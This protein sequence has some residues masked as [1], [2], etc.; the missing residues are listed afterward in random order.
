MD[1]KKHPK[2]F[3]I[4]LNYNG[5]RT[6]SRCLTSIY[7]SDYPN[8]E[9]IVVD[10]ASR[11]GSIETIR[12]N[13]QTAHIIINQANL[14]FAAGNNVAIRFALEK[15]ADY[16]LLLN[17]DAYLEPKTISALVLQAQ[18][19]KK[20]GMIN[21]LIL[22]SEGELW[23]EGGKIDWL[24]MRTFHSKLESEKSSN[25]LCGCALLISKEV[26]HKIGLFDEKFFLYYEDADL[27][28]RAKKA[29]F[30]LMIDRSI[31]I[32]HDEQSESAGAQKIYWLVLSGIIFFKKHTPSILKPWMYF[33]L[34]LRRLKNARDLAGGKNE[35]A[36]AVRRAYNDASKL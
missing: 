20:V 14:G 36:S 8:F 35:V 5:K 10:N 12:Q 16:V 9:T 31:K 34:M 21:P 30:S 22:N 18:K 4:V 33:Y 24:K 13:F 6:I 28:L 32:I 2:V 3:V 7:H 15:F 17:N 19:D 23:F 29:G 27:S 1:N 11:D 26:F 25:Y